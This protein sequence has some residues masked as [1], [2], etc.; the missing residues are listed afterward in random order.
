MLG[1]QPQLAERCPWEKLN[2]ENWAG[3][4]DELPQSVKWCPWERLNGENWVELLIRRPDFGNHHPW[5]KLDGRNW[6]ELL[7]VQ[8]M[9]AAHCSW[10]KLNGRDWAYLL[11]KRREFAER[12]PWEDLDIHAWA[13]LLRCQ[14]Q[15]IVR[16]RELASQGNA[17]AQ[18]WLGNLCGNAT[19][20]AKWFREAAAQGNA[21]AQCRLGDIYRAGEGLERNLSEAISWYRRSSESGD[22]R[23]PYVLASILFEQGKADE[24]LPFAE[25]AAKVTRKNNPIYWKIEAL[26]LLAEIL[27]SI[28]NIE[29][30]KSVCQEALALFPEKVTPPC[31]K[32]LGF[33]LLPEAYPDPY[34]CELSPEERLGVVPTER[35]SIMRGTVLMRLGHACRT[36]GDIADARNAFQKALAIE[37]ALCE[38]VANDG[39]S[40]KICRERAKKLRRLI[41]ES[42]GV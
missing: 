5:D 6:A 37:E 29:R 35:L 16:L 38:L 31:G 33:V 32:K 4:F 8:P 14:P 15:F 42:G 28:G 22:A 27:D 25:R 19:E 18:V 3:L 7:G 39:I 36:L 34:G 24:A 10:K 17:Q 9:F 2:G 26:E 12:C 41:K 40:V 21:E 13:W 1:K 23:A 11:A 30:T 20:A